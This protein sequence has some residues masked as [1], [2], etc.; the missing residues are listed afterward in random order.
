MVYSFPVEYQKISL[1]SIVVFNFKLGQVKLEASSLLTVWITLKLETF[2]LHM[3][4]LTIPVS[5]AL[6]L[7]GIIWF[8]ICLFEKQ[9]VLGKT[10]MAFCTAEQIFLSS[11]LFFNPKYYF[12]TMLL[13]S[14]ISIPYQ[15]DPVCAK[16]IFFVKF[17]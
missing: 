2:L 17:P 15:E 16:T 12:R 5:N 6:F 11:L 14:T 4:L 13:H 10:R 9:V 1:F 8:R 3:T 7:E